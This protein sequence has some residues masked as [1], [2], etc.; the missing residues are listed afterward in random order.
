MSAIAPD[1]YLAFCE[2]L[3]DICGIDLTQYKRPQMERRLRSFFERRGLARLTDSLESLRRDPQALEDLLDR[4][5]INVSQLWRHPEQWNW[6]RRGILEDLACARGRV[7]AWSA[8]CS[9]G[10]EAYTLAAECLETIP[11]VPVEILGTDINRRMIARAREG[12]FT[13]HDARGAPAQAVARFFDPTPEGWRVKPALRALTRFDVGDLLT[14]RPGTSIYDLVMCR[15]TV[16]YFSEP[17]RDELH[18]RLARS[19]R[20]GG[21]LVIGATERVRAPAQLGLES[22]HPFI[23]RKL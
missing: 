12:V 7:R 5:T 6:L 10:A 3:R 17:I 4:V 23:L 13:R 1:D 8:G 14:I 18:A 19:L 2:G 21:Y 22:I 11:G 20:P 9:H 16:I 15:N